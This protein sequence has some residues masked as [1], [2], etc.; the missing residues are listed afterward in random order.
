MRR[1][2]T[3]SLVPRPFLRQIAGAARTARVGA[4]HGFWAWTARAALSFPSLVGLR[5][6]SAFAKAFPAPS[7]ASHNPFPWADLASTRERRLPSLGADC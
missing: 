6:L 1:E 5:A 2:K 4:V 3:A 7:D